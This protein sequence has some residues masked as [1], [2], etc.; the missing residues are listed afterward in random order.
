[1]KGLRDNYFGFLVDSHITD[2]DTSNL[3]QL[4]PEGFVEKMKQTGADSAMV[5]A[6]LPQRQLLLP[7]K[8]RPR[9][10]GLERA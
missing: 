5:Y 4:T 9:A 3:S 1:M 10:S 7:H 6:M 2:H 8:G